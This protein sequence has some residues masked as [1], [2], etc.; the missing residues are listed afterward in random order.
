MWFRYSTLRP[1]QDVFDGL[2][3][4]P[5]VLRGTGTPVI[6]T[7][8]LVDSGALVNVLPFDLGNRLGWIW[9]EEEAIIHLA[10]SLGS[11]PA[12]PA[13]AIATIG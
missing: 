8:G 2:P 9:R 12:V 10:G 13:F 6:E 1:D 4:V 5:L 3:R 11:H 7:A